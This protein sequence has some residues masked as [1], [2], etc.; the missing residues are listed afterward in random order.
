[1]KQAKE[2]PLVSATNEE[3]GIS[4]FC[5]LE[6]QLLKVIDTEGELTVHNTPENVMV[7]L[8]QWVL[9][10]GNSK[11]DYRATA[12]NLLNGTLLRYP[13]LATIVLNNLRY[14]YIKIVSL[15]PRSHRSLLTYI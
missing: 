10:L 4:A 13:V 3:S 2:L 6:T 14:V 12:Y 8:H 5:K 7:E 9:H 11:D 1:M 15:T